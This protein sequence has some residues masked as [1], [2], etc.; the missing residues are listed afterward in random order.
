MTAK[1]RTGPPTFGIF[2]DAEPR[3]NGMVLSEKER[4]EISRIK[5]GKKAKTGD[6]FCGKCG[7]PIPKGE[8]QANVIRLRGARNAIAWVAGPHAPRF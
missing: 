5:C 3:V 6:E 8:T 7:A 1:G 2:L 4:K